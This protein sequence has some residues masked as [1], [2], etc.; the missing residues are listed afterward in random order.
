MGSTLPFTI[1]HLLMELNIRKSGHAFTREAYHYD[2]SPFYAILASAYATR[3]SRPAK[4][5]KVD[6]KGVARIFQRGGHTVSKVKKKKG[7]LAMAKIS[8]WHFRH[9]L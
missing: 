9:L 4:R 8:S 3:H 1:Y 2:R 5:Y 7:F 6:V